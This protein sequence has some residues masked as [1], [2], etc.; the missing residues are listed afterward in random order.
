MPLAVLME[1]VPDSLNHGR[2]NIA[3]ETSEV[4][5]VKGHVC[6]YTLLNAAYYGGPQMRERFFLIG[7]RRE[8][9]SEVTFPEPTH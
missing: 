2:Q 6:G 5:E 3:E 1:N 8:L 7:Y 4:L 9:V